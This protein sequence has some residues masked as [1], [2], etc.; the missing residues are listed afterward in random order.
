MQDSEYLPQY[1]SNV[2]PLNSLPDLSHPGNVVMEAA[3][4]LENSWRS[5]MRPES[6]SSKPQDPHMKPRP[7]PPI[8]NSDISDY[9]RASG[10]FEY[11]N[12]FENVPER[13]ARSPT[14]PSAAAPQILPNRP[15]NSIKKRKRLK[16]GLSEKRE[17]RHEDD[18]IAIAGT[19]GEDG[20]C[21]NSQPAT[22]EKAEHH[23]YIANMPSNHS[24]DLP[25][26]KPK[27]TV[28]AKSQNKDNL[29]D[30]NST[31]RKVWNLNENSLDY[32]FVISTFQF[33]AHPSY[34]K[35]LEGLDEVFHTTFKPSSRPLEFPRKTWPLMKDWI[36]A[37]KNQ[38]IYSLLNEIC[39]WNSAFLWIFTQLGTNELKISEQEKMCNWLMEQG[40]SDRITADL[41]NFDRFST[42]NIL[43]DYLEEMDV[44]RQGFPAKWDFKPASPEFLSASITMGE[45]LGMQTKRA[46]H[47]LADY[48]ESKNSKKWRILFRG[49]DDFFRLFALLIKAGEDFQWVRFISQKKSVERL[50]FIPW[51]D[52]KIYTPANISKIKKKGII[53]TLRILN[54]HRFMKDHAPDHMFHS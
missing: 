35:D 24:S 43:P 39:H 34:R 40:I 1:M 27:L 25:I 21:L 47:T 7:P 29:G 26:V 50:D 15:G 33:P 45:I 16:V 9:P 13:L 23:E 11:S 22:G 38:I 30:E 31:T 17:K 2:K 6:L 8:A 19:N 28:K 37:T 14:E 20:I 41:Q 44:K 10:D 51:Q 53:H 18:P 49:R 46:L 36:N 5:D 48:Y 4:R 12:D 52:E 42:R 32:F 54:I 3:A